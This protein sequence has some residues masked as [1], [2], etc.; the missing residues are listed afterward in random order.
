M[1]RE[2]LLYEIGL[3]YQEL[4][5]YLISKYG[6]AKYN[7]FATEECKTKSKKVRR[8]SEGLFCH[9][10]REDMGGELSDEYWARLQPFEWQLK[11]NLVYCNFLEH[12]LLHIKIAVLRQKRKM[13]KPDEISSFITTG[14][15]FFIAE[16]VNDLYENHGSPQAW[17]QRC[18]EEISNNYNDYLLLLNLVTDYISNQ[19]IGKKGEDYYIRIGAVVQY[20]GKDYF[21][22]EISKEKDQILIIA[23]DGPRFISTYFAGDQLTYKDHIDLVSRRLCKG[24]EKLCE[25]IYTDFCD[26]N[27]V[28][29]PDLVEALKVD[30]RGY[31]FPQF[32]GYKLDKKVYGAESIDEYISNAYPLYSSENIDIGENLPTFWRGRPPE[33]VK[34]GACNYFVRV[35][36]CFTIKEGQEPFVRYKGHDLIHASSSL[37]KEI[38]K[39]NNLMK[40]SG[41]IFSTSYIYNEEDNRYYEFYKFPDGKVRQATIVITFWKNDFKLFCE[42]HD[43]KSL[44]YLDGCYFD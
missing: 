1:K 22:K 10:V 39:E 25:H 5:D 23:A 11:E 18:Y 37:S 19:Y 40:R 4:V 8:T 13:E 12:L 29:L 33:V 28:V 21:I 34:R 3:T 43:I 16:V 7:Y 31:G 24:H 9:H 2:E 26:Y 20:L 44:V 41:V 30:F 36:T 35:E 15:V 38:S 6:P 42:R 14:G 27:D 17:L 32:N